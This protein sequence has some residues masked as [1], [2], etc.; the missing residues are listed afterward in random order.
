LHCNQ[1]RSLRREKFRIYFLRSADIGTATRNAAFELLRLAAPVKRGSIIGGEA[2]R[3]VEGSEGAIVILFDEVGV[4]KIF[5]GRD[6]FGVEPDRLV[7]I[8]YRAVK[9]AP[10]FCEQAPT[11]IEC[12]G[13][14]GI[15]P[16]RFAVIRDS[17]VSL[18]FDLVAFRGGRAGTNGKYKV[19]LAGFLSFVNG[20]LHGLSQGFEIAS[21]RGC[22]PPDKTD[23]SA[24]FRRRKALEHHAL[25]AHFQFGRNLGEQ[26]DPVTVGDHLHHCH[27]RGRAQC[28]CGIAS[29]IA[30]S[31][32]LVA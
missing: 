4:A 16:N 29:F 18:T 19:A 14:L 28:R 6:V 7:E 10:F 1:I 32:R 27:E 12:M 20:S 26:C 3:L 23:R 24:W 13:I 17:A 2:D 22:F 31:E 8:R 11:V 5:K 21:T 15:E 9:I 25:I 30:E